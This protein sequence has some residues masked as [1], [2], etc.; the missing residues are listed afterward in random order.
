MA[1]AAGYLNIVSGVTHL[2]GAIFILIFGWLGDGVFNILWYGMVG[3]P[4]TPITQPVSQE[5]Q[6]LLAIPVIILSILVI[7]AGIFAIKR[8]KWSIVLIGS[9]CGT[10][11]TWFLGLPAILFTILSKNK[12][13]QSV[14]NGKPLKTMQILF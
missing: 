12:F 14:T 13:Q 1:K 4:L 11:I 8:R 6:S 10:L 3:T 7:I 9:I 5:L 2:L